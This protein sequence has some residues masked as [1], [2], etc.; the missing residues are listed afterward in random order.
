MAV[1]VKRPSIKGT[2]LSHI[3][4]APRAFIV[5]LEPTV[6]DGNIVKVMCWYDGECG[7]TSQMIRE[8]LS[9]ATVSKKP[10]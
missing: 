9:I 8:A 6:V 1:A 5:N 3:I 7:C 4:Q 2:E 10:L